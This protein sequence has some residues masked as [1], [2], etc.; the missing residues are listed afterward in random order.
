MT[1]QIQYQLQY[2]QWADKRTLDAAALIDPIHFPSEIAF[3][4]QQLNHMVRVEEVFRARLLGTREPHSASNS[5]AVPELRE[6]KERLSASNDWLLK[7]AQ[8]TPPETMTGKIR[9]RFFDGQDGTMSREEILFHLVN[10]GTY[11]RGAIGRA[12]DLAGGL[13]PADTYTVF[14]HAMEPERR[15]LRGNLGTVPL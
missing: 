6:L 12:L 8:S 14:V 9:F 2:K 3:A 4:R 11:H 15:S 10:H 13:R 1:S 7:F 5:E